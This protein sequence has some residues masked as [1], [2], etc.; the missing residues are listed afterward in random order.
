MNWNKAKTILIIAFIILNVF[1]FYEVQDANNESYEGLSD[2]FINHVVEK[3]L[4]KNIVIE[5]EVPEEIYKK[6]LLEV[7]YYL[8]TRED[9]AKY[10]GEDYEEVLENTLFTNEEGSYVRIENNKK[11]IYNIRDVNG[12]LEISKEDALQIIDK[13]KENQNMDIDDY[14]LDLIVKKDNIYEVIYKRY[15]EGN[16]LENDYYKFIIDNIGVAGFETQRISK[17][18]PKEGL[19]T[20]TSAY[21]SLLRL[22]NENPEEKT[23]INKIEICYYTDEN[24]EG[25]ENILRANM[26]PTWKVITERGNI[27][28][29]TEVE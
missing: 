28:Y 8:V 29:L 14:K 16:F 21:E 5:G 19:I 6:P 26:D 1:L 27:K 20:V 2:E 18:E 4:E 7:E 10:I 13:Y 15:Y 9:V 23:I 11:L 12:S 22:K 17:I 3:L 25:W 24:I